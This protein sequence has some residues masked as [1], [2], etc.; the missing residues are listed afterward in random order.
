[1]EING[2][3]K[4]YRSC[5]TRSTT[6]PVVNLPKSSYSSPTP[7]PHRSPL[8]E[9]VAG[10]QESFDSVRVGSPKL[11][12][13]SPTETERCLVDY[14]K[15]R[16]LLREVKKVELFEQNRQLNIDKKFKWEAEEILFQY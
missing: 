3:R 12:L 4:F 15:G 16:G 10:F 11:S 5:S 14:N 7:P 2:A 1:M 13:S 8:W 9:G 6:K